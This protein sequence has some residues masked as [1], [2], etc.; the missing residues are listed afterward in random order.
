[1]LSS[2]DDGLHATTTGPQGSHVLTS[3]LAA[4]GLALVEAGDGAMRRGERVQVEL[5]S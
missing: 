1:M 3:M 2:A 4:D 5:L